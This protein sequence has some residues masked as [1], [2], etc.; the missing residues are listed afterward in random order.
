MRFVDTNI[1]LYSLDLEPAQPEKTKIATEILRCSDVVLSVQVL[2]EFYV[3]ATHPRRPDALPHDIA[4][5]LIQKWMRFHI[6]ENTVAVLQSAL[7]IKGRFQ[8][9]YWDAAI[10]AA[11]KAAGCEEVLTE[12]L[13]HGQDYDGVSVV[14]PFR[15]QKRTG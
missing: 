2:Q 12:D 13:N 4:T 15:G 6:Q 14:N 10:L 9:S 1:L 5:R 7:A 3:Q 11:A 8:T